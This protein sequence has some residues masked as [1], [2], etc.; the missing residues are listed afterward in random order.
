MIA[1]RYMYCNDAKIVAFDV[2]TRHVQ[3]STPYASCRV[4]PAL[5]IGDRYFNLS[6]ISSVS[7]LG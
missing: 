3:Y 2:D 6:E 5:K 4:G 7:V 1:G